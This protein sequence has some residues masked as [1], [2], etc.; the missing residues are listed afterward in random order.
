MR[1]PASPRFGA[2]FLLL[3]GRLGHDPAGLHPPAAPAGAVRSGALR[4]PRAQ[5]AHT[6]APPNPSLGGAFL[7]SLP[8]TP[9][10]IVASM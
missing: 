7:V 8:V 3:A 2:S 9:S 6:D 4:T 1:R 5:G 10:L